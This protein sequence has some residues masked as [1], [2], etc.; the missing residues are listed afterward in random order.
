MNQLHILIAVVASIAVAL[1]GFWGLNDAYAQDNAT[2]TASNMTGNMT[3]GNATMMAGNV[4]S[5]DN[6][7]GTISSRGH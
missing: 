3:A 6:S 7:T 2:M 4:T 5:A 1:G